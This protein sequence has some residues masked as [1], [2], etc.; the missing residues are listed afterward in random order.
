MDPGITIGKLLQEDVKIGTESG[1]RMVLQS[2][3]IWRGKCI[4]FALKMVVFISQ[5][6]KNLN[7]VDFCLIWR[8]QFI[9]MGWY[10]EKVICRMGSFIFHL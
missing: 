7:K 4:A 2:F 8:V 3:S 10:T 6:I 9:R 1:E 5:I